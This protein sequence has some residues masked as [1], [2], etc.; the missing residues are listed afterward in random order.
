MKIP[1]TLQKP[2]MSTP[3]AI[4]IGIFTIIVGAIV[5]IG[6]AFFQYETSISAPKSSLDDTRQRISSISVQ[7]LNELKSSMNNLTAEYYE[8]TFDN[9]SV[10]EVKVR[11][12]DNIMI[13]IADIYSDKQVKDHIVAEWHSGKSTHR[14]SVCKN[15][16]NRIVKGTKLEV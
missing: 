1:S 10:E 3:V 6:I 2:E 5:P 11:V 9:I 16:A 14:C 8:K 15:I 4:V 7:E 13:A 12:R